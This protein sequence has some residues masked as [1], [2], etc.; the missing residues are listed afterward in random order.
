MA[1]RHQVIICGAGICGVSAAYF[2]ARAGLSDILLIDERAPL[3]LTSDRSTE[4]YRNWWPDPAIVSL[5]NRSIELMDQLSAH[6]HNAFHLNRRGYLYV[7]G[8]EGHVPEFARSASRVSELGGGPLRI[9]ETIGSTYVRQP[10]ADSIGQP[11]GADLLLGNQVI[12][13]H[14]PYLT[15]KA[16]AA[17]HVRK[18]G[19]LS[20][21]QLG[22]HLLNQARGMGAAVRVGRVAEVKVAGGQVGGVV[23]SNGERLDCSA[24]VDAAGPYL[25]PVA[26]MLGVELPVQTELHLMAML[27]DPLGV[28]RRDAPLL[29]WDEEQ[30]LPWQPEELELLSSD[31]ETRWL[32][33]VLPPGAHTR[34][35]GSAGSKTIL[36]LWD[37]RPRPQEPVLPPPL[38]EQYPEIALRGLST[39][40]PGLQAYFGRAARPELDGGYYVK[41][42]ENRLLACPLP[43]EG[44]YVLGAVSGYGIMAACGAGELLAAH[45]LG[46]PLP[47]YA[48][49]FSLNRYDDPNYEQSLAEWTHSG[50]L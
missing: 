17:L 47:S 11:D 49:A 23:L 25:K 9:H 15:S 39:M 1:P 3:T 48:S 28:V 40:L 2:L 29:I 7:I 33:G 24:F 45:I 36:M 10:P 8:D 46:R 12:A 35:E 43:L 14:F 31:E 22:M 38:D 42:P 4:C 32:T 34:P 21:Q 37:Y 26:D 16:V 27:K 30:S 18:A 13:T 5:T 6:S 20:A 50:Q 19:W 44:A 41:T